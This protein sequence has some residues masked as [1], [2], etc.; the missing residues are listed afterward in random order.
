MV[1]FLPLVAVTGVTGSFFRALAITM[2]VSL[3]TS[4]LLAVTFTP[5]L[6]LLLLGERKGDEAKAHADAEHGEA[7]PVL[8]R[9]LYW[10]KRTLEW[11]LSRPVWLGVF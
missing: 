5:G 2:T 10:H 3:L 9:I 1:V 6:A 4:L 7:G 11:A 8:G